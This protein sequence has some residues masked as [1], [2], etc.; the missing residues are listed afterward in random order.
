[1]KSR[2]RTN[3]SPRCPA[4][5]LTRI[6]GSFMRVV[7]DQIARNAIRYL[8]FPSRFIRQRDPVGCLNGFLHCSHFLIGQ[9]VVQEPS[10]PGAF[11][12]SEFCIFW[13]FPWENDYQHRSIIIDRLSHGKTIISRILAALPLPPDGGTVARWRHSRRRASHPPQARHLQRA[14]K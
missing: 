9:E 8:N 13:Q 12:G 3:A 11:P 14:G 4:L 2:D 5:P 10:L 1:M 6:N 7:L